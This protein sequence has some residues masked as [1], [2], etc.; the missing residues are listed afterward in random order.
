MKSDYQRPA[1]PDDRPLRQ[2]IPQIM[3]S[4][5]DGTMLNRGLRGE[6]TDTELAKYSTE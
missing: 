6:T 2:G 5:P 1:H 4:G 3:L